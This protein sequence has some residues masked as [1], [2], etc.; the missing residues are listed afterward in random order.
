MKRNTSFFLVA[1]ILVM[2]CQ[3]SESV[4]QTAM[5]QTQDALP[6]PILAPTSTASPLPTQTPSLTLSPTITLTP[7][8]TF[9]PTLT[10]TPTSTSTPIPPAALTKQAKAATATLLA[11]YTAIDWREL[12]TYPD[13]HIGELVKV[14]I[15]IFNIIS[16]T[17]LQGW[18]DRTYEAI[19]VVM[20]EPFSG[21]YEDDA[22]TVYGIVQGKHC[23]TNAFGGEVCQPLLIDAFW[24]RR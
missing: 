21:I 16:S 14:K 19:F 10:F 4:I 23:S 18:F 15:K 2:G 24:E 13:N 6:T 20:R 11:Q 22:I 8:V 5:A 12:N 9:T 3:P 7:T 17:Q 1:V